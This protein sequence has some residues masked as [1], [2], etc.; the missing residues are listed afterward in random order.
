MV[1]VVV[2]GVVVVV[3]VAMAAAVVVLAKTAVMA[4]MPLWHRMQNFGLGHFSPHRPVH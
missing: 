4:A 2:V 1:G 3:A